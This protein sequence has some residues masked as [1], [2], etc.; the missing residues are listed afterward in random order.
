[1]NAQPPRLQQSGGLLAYGGGMSWF[2]DLIGRH[3]LLERLG[4]HIWE[5][6]LAVW[7]TASILLLLGL[8]G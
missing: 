6:G 2:Q 8:G 5:L 3:P 4:Y 1:M 7:L